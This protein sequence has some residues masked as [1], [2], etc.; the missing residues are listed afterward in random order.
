VVI[1]DK[2]D[3]LSSECPWVMKNLWQ[4][5]GVAMARDPRV[6]SIA[7]EIRAR[8]QEALR[9]PAYHEADGH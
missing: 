6:A 9:N 7:R 1:G 8:A 5:A 2:R 4:Q 3:E